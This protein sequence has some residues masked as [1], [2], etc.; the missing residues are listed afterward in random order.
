MKKNYL[1]AEIVD[2]ERAGDGVRLDIP[3]GMLVVR[4]SQ[5]GPYLTI[6]FEAKTKDRYG[7]LRRFLNDTLHE[8][9]ELDWAS[10]INVNLEA[11]L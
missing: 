3:D 9:G 10:S 2:D 7:E 4:Y 6:K 8:F 1:S 5:N 11:L